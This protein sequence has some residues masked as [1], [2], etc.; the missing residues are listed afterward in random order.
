MVPGAGLEPARAMGILSPHCLPIPTPRLICSESRRNNPPLGICMPSKIGPALIALFQELGKL[1][2]AAWG[3]AYARA[4]AVRWTGLLDTQSDLTGRIYRQHLH[5]GFLV[6]LHIIVDVRHMRQRSQRC[7]P[8]RSRHQAKSQKRRLMIQQ[9]SSTALLGTYLAFLPI[10]V[11]KSVNCYRYACFVSSG[12][13]LP[14][15]L[16]YFVHIWILDRTWLYSRYSVW[17]S[18]LSKA[19]TR[20]RSSEG[21][22]PANG[23]ARRV[24]MKAVVETEMGTL[25]LMGGIPHHRPGLGKGTDDPGRHAVFPGILVP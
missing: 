9:R 18:Q 5:L 16:H 15:C 17:S 3:R 6:R 12:S 1:S 2:S 7:V 20:S 13:P 19:P 8:N 14:T 4:S 10:L 22:S 23:S 24:S 25:A 11:D 21:V